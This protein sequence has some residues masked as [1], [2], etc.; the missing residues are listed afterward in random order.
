MI[1]ITLGDHDWVDIEPYL[2]QALELP[3][4]ERDDYV[5]EL[6]AQRPG[7]AAALKELLAE[8]DEL[9]SK[10]FLND[11]VMN[12]SDGS[13]LGQQVGA[14]T[15]DS[16][17]GRGGMGEVWL[18]L[19]SDGRFEGKF[20]LKF[21]DSFAASAVALDQAFRREGRLLARLSHLHIARLIDAG[22]T[23]GGRPYLVLEYIDG[24]RI[25]RYC[26]SH[27]LGIEAR[28]RLLLDVLSALAH[29]HSNLVV[30]RDIKPSNVL[31]T[32]DGVAKLVDFG[33]GKLLSPD[34][35]GED[36]SGLPATRLEDSALT[37]EYAAPE[38]FLGEP[39]STATDVYQLGVLMFVLLAGRLTHCN[40]GNH[41]RRAHQSHAGHGADAPVVCSGA[42]HAQDVARRSGC[43]RLEGTA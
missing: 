28:V 23:S 43:H 26:E 41:A 36:S 19:R 3:A 21:L 34:I 20:A 5:T 27:S 12:L 24:E 42:R 11:P 8:R 6:A 40:P 17:I 37:P 15:I 13:L 29:A 30:H 4:S 33:I 32:K 38:Q 1:K 16:L 22:V 10:G 7:I 31:V 39:A 9:E 18:A 25:D 14:Y 35:Q 2:D